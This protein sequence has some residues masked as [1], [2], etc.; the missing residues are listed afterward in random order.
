MKDKRDNIFIS[1]F[2]SAA[3]IATLAFAS[4]CLVFG[5]GASTT[6]TATNADMEAE[7]LRLMQIV[8]EKRKAVHAV[9]GSLSIVDRPGIGPRNAD[10]VLI[11]FGDFQCPYCRRHMLDTAQE[12]F[13]I[14]VSDNRLRYVFL[15]FPMETKHPLAFKAAVAAH[16]AEEQDKY[17]E[18]RNI[19]YKSQKA[20]HEEFLLG[21]AKTAGLDEAAFS[22]CIDSE[23]HNAAIQQDQLAGKS[24]GVK[25]TPAF[26]IGINNGKE[27]RL[28]RRI[29]GAQPYEVFE[30]EILRAQK[31]AKVA[32]Y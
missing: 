7:Y 26:Y 16:C 17:W 14:L 29:E 27:V 24:L 15:D 31:S 8:K 3:L 18:M 30:R 32:T 13:K 1:T 20:I 6:E 9:R 10:V 5:G 2:R 22:N 19:L 28:V 4:P 25:G 12:I 21:H 23:R 11:E